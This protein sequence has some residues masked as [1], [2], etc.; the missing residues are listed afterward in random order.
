MSRQVFEKIARRDKRTVGYL[1][2]NKFNFP[3]WRWS[4]ACKIQNED[5][6][7]CWKNSGAAWVKLFQGLDTSCN[8]SCFV[9]LWGIPLFGSTGGLYCVDDGSV[10]GSGVNTQFC[11]VG[12]LCDLETSTSR[13]WDIEFEL[14]QWHLSFSSSGKEDLCTRQWI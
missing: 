4:H 11:A 6:K 2:C 14:R 1:C 9:L 5:S 8:D 3:F 10:V 12:N 13:E 7:N